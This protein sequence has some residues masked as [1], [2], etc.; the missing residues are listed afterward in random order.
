[1]KL[2]NLLTPQKLKVTVGDVEL[3]F[4]KLTWKELTAFQKFATEVDE[5]D[6]QES[7]L[8][9]CKHILEN[10][11]TD[12]N[13]EEVIDINKVEELPVEFCV[14]L[15]EKFIDSTRGDSNEDIKKK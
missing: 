4:K 6:E 8:R 7:A 10:Y 3:Y 15:V 14:K 1:M 12:E 5:E 11:V 13:D 9:L 2:D